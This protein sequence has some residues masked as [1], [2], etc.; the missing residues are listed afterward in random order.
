[1]SKHIIITK[2][3]KKN[4]FN[5]VLGVNVFYLTDKKKLNQFL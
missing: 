1:M 5:K 4:V 2:S 3:I